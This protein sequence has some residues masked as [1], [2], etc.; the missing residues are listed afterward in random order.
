M[1]NRSRP[2]SRIEPS[3]NLSLAT[4]KNRNKNA[5]IKRTNNWSS[6]ERRMNYN[7]PK[8]VSTYL[9]SAK[10]NPKLFSLL[11]VNYKVTNSRGTS[12][13]AQFRRYSD[14]ENKRLFGFSYRSNKM[15]DFSMI[16][17]ILKQNYYNEFAKNKKT[18]NNDQEKKNNEDENSNTKIKKDN[19]N[20]NEEQ[21][22]ILS[23]N[24]S[25]CGKTFH[26]N[27]INFLT[28]KNIN[29]KSN[30][31]NENTK[32]EVNQN[33]NN[34]IENFKNNTIENVR[35]NYIES[36]KNN[37]IENVKNNN[38]QNFKY[39]TI[40]NV[41]NNNILNFKNNTIENAKNNNFKNFKNNDI[42]IK[43]SM[44]S[45]D[46]KNS[47]KNN[48]T[49]NKNQIKII[50][51]PS[52]KEKENEKQLNS[53]SK[54]QSQSQTKFK[55]R[56]QTDRWMPK[57]Y[58]S[59]EEMVKNPTL[60]KKRL[61]NDPFISRFPA[62]S[63]KQIKEK[64]NES[65]IFFVKDVNPR[66]EKVPA[67]NTP[68]NYQ[69]SDIFNLKNDDENLLK[70][71]EKYLF[72]P[73]DDKEKYSITR[74]SK[75]NWKPKSTITTFMNSP[76]EEYNILN[77]SKKNIAKTK[78]KII[79]ECEKKRDSV[80]KN[81]TGVNFFNPIY[82]QKGISEFIDTTRNGGNNPGVDFI[83]CFNKNPKCFYKQNE[84]CSNFY[85]SYLTYKNICSKPFILE[86]SMK[87]NNMAMSLK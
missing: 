1:N 36:F 54:S 39:N 16:R 46:I 50:L 37:T 11:D 60:F 81:P 27:K 25:G 23:K 61:Y 53:V 18:E 69:N 38:I 34:N 3:G 75:S 82:R 83:N 8:L 15:Y 12:L 20:T 76:S 71:S 2:L 31:N 44:S 79:I 41:K 21:K 9:N 48:I 42:E 47:P 58:T 17:K 72:R 63:L 28:P 14:E 29:I 5:T 43:Q 19:K 84:V 40:E 33:K 65:D 10:Y 49:K 68:H 51:H 57:G 67:Q 24:F 62:V 77:P 6:Y 85:D 87:I 59:Y 74:E 26:R 52:K 4:S 78:E 70:C 35:N 86:D 22:I 80:Q 30:T 7:S 73:K 55:I 45:N 66:K 13:P 64:S 32:K 56:N